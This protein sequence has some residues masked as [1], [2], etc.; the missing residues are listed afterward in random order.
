MKVL[1]RDTYALSPRKIA[2]VT[3]TAQ[4]ARVP[5]TGTGKTVSALAMM[6]AKTRNALHFGN[7]VLRLHQLGLVTHPYHKTDA[8]AGA[9]EMKSTTR[10][11][12]LDVVEVKQE[13]S[14]NLSGVTL[15]E[16]L[17]SMGVFAVL[18]SM[19][20]P[21]V[22][23]ATESARRAQCAVRLG[24]L[25]KACHSF[26]ATHQRLPAAKSFGLLR[27]YPE[28]L[29]PWGQLLP[30]I[31]QTTIFRSIDMS[32]QGEDGVDD[33]AVSFKNYEVMRVTL[34][35][36][37]CPSDTSA[38]GS[39]NFRACLGSRYGRSRPGL[40][41]AFWS[42]VDD[43]TNV[44]LGQ[45]RD[46]LS[47]T[48]LCSERL[49]GD[50]DPKTYTPIRDVYLA[51]YAGPSLSDDSFASFCQN[52]YPGLG[53]H[54]SFLGSTWFFR[55]KANTS[56]NHA[57]GPNSAVPDCGSDSVTLT[58]AAVSARSWHRGGVNAAFADGATRFVNQNISLPIWL[59]IGTRA[60]NEVVSEW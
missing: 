32:E 56:Y 28:G 46:G 1:N 13:A 11:R 8:D 12:F 24:Q 54:L 35:G 48:V 53:T 21:A 2:F 44:T 6:K 10:R 45:I 17:V 29:S 20:L 49:L 5:C 23:N 18:V 19:L 22:L 60:G 15:I 16:V 51:G 59:A 4:F 40:V 42:R 14:T 57:L 30:F 36:L 50:F 41:G 34:V 25:A 31:D 39:C 33:P 37:V 58:D 52:S 9:C 3:R 7:T 47:Q 55:G 43:P 38:P 26:H 27:P